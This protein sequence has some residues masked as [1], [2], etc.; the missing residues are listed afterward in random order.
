MPAA[1]KPAQRRSKPSAKASAD[2]PLRES[3]AALRETLTRGVVLTRD[4]IND[5]LDDAVRRGRMTR[6]DAEE[7]GASLM[8]IGRRQAQDLLADVEQLLGSGRRRTSEGTDALVRQVDRARR[9]AGLGSAFPIMGYDDLTAA[10][11]AERLTDLDNADLRKVR[12]YER[13]NANRKSVLTAV[14]RALG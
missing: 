3:L 8:G 13:R 4:R 10:Q 14:D 12:D 6:D 11:V 2:A 5:T 7:L 1:K 9:A